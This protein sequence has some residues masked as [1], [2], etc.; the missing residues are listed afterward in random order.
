MSVQPLKKFHSIKLIPADEFILNKFSLK[1]S[2]LNI[3]I[4]QE[5]NDLLSLI[6]EVHNYT[7]IA[8]SKGYDNKWNNNFRKEK[9]KP[10]PQI[11]QSTTIKVS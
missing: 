7:Y 2:H 1:C 6:S 11:S 3:S 4:R 10:N 5:L 8:Y 9:K